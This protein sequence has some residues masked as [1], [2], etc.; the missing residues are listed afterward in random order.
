MKRAQDSAKLQPRDTSSKRT[1]QSETPIYVCKTFFRTTGHEGRTPGPRVMKE[2]PQA[3]ARDGSGFACPDDGA[4]G[5]G[6]G[7]VC[8]L[9]QRLPR[10]V[11]SSPAAKI[12]AGRTLVASSQ[13]K[14][15]SGLGRHGDED[16]K[17]V[18][19]R[20]DAGQSGVKRSGTPP[21]TP[22]GEGATA[23]SL[24]LSQSVRH[25]LPSPL[26]PW[27]PAVRSLRT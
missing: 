25:Q 15:S 17:K 4:G 10:H 5:T 23:E 8:F 2:G 6:V 12:W 20:N 7:S 13:P 27:K 1:S 3:S 14:R 22:A 11:S 24:R 19:C 9:W 21:P 26:L 16:M 18:I